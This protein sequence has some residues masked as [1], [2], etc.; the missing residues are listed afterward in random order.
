LEEKSRKKH[1]DYVVNDPQEVVG[2]YE[3]IGELGELP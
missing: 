1:A 3:H 2:I